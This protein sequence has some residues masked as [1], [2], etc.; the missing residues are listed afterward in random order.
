MN[1][2]AWISLVGLLVGLAAAGCASAP[3]TVA[4]APPAAVARL[5]VENLTDYRWRIAV[6]SAGGGE[7]REARVRARGSV[8][9]MFTGGDYVI[10]QTVVDGNS[11]TDL[12]R[13]LP[14]RLDPGRTYRWRLVTLLSDPTTGT[15][16]P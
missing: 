11:G 2:C 16:P 3:P 6:T 14:A 12:Y 13:R 9:L 4:V 8:E 7:V 10:E 15:L 1:S 5:V